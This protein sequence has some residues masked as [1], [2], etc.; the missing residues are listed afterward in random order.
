MP[1]R[2]RPPVVWRRFAL[3]GTHEHPFYQVAK[4]QIKPVPS[5]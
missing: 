4:G 5:G 2:T 3:T 1:C